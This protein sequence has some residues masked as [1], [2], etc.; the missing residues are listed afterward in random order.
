MGQFTF[1]TMQGTFA[2]QRNCRGAASFKDSL[3]G[4]TNY[5]FTVVNDGETIFLQY[6]DEATAFAG[7]A[8]RMR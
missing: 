4:V 5:A 1:R 6:A 3:G 8:Q 7:V 2:V